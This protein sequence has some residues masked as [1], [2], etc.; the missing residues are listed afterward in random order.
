MS[1]MFM[2]VVFSLCAIPR[3]SAETVSLASVMQEALDKNPGL[4]AARLTWSAAD[5][6]IRKKG[7]LPDP[8]MSVSHMSKSVQTRGGPIKGKVLVS[9]DVPFFQ[10]RGLR[11][12]AAQRQAEVAQEGYRAKTLSL[13]MH[14]VRA[15]YDLFFVRKAKGILEEQVDLLRHFARVAEKKYSVRKGPQATVFRAQAELSRMKN[16]VITMDQRQASALAHLNTLLDREPLM[17]IADLE[18]P[19]FPVIAWDKKELRRRALSERPEIKAAQAL[20]GRSRAEKRQA[21]RDFF[22]DFRIG[23]EYTRIGGGTTQA[24][25]D[26]R[27]AHGLSLGLNLPLWGR[28]KRSGYLEASAI[29]AGA[30][31]ALREIKNRTQF[32]VE[33]LSVRAE[34]AMR[35]AQVDEDTILPQIRAALKATSSGYESDSVGF[36]DVLDAERALLKMEIEHLG[37]IVRFHNLV[38]ELERVVG[39]QI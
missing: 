33:D 20:M 9:Q 6:I 18:A 19:P 24:A 38:A 15:Y 25:F 32:E 30:A 2:L 14:V 23:Y 31:M 22:P 21:L 35:V 8:R 26:G 13:K 39:G 17:E 12:E 10:K 1:R 5:A 36:L 11:R 4:K 28:A 27:D 3:V 37:H 29:E 34:T 16:E 7:A